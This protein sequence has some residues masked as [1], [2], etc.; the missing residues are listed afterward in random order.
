[1]FPE[2]ESSIPKKEIVT[3]DSDWSTNLKK[4]TRGRSRKR[5]ISKQQNNRY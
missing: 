4:T 2:L 3:E 5:T 1:M